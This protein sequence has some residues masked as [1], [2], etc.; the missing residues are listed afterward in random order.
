MNKSS[1]GVWSTL[2]IT[3]TEGLDMVATTAKAMSVTMSTAELTASIFRAN[4]LKEQMAELG[5]EL[6]TV[7]AFALARRM[8]DAKYSDEK[9]EE[10]LAELINPTKRPTRRK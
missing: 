9:L 10:I 5:L 7:Q 2:K 1:K 6:D 3:T 4:T 8:A